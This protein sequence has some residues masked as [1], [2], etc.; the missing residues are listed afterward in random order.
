M[1]F[2]LDTTKNLEVLDGICFKIYQCSNSLT[3]IYLKLS[4]NFE[5]WEEL[6]H[7]SY[8]NKYFKIF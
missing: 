1:E 2:S 5:M 4:K 3:A 8:E 6:S 7:S